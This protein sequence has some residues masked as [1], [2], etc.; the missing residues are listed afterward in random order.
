MIIA[1]CEVNEVNQTIDGI[2]FPYD[3]FVRRLMRL[4]NIEINDYDRSNDEMYD[5]KNK[6]A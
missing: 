3:E 4:I 5:R 6:M 1:D 2:K